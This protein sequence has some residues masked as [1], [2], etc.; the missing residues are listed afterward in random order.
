MSK[1]NPQGQQPENRPQLNMSAAPDL[2]YK[3]RDLFNVHVS[4]EDVLLEFGNLHRSQP[5]SAVLLDRIVLSPGNA[6]RLQQALAQAI[7]QMQQKIREMAA[8]K[9]PASG[10]N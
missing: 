8:Q 1:D 7:N 2:D 3:Y 10:A 9:P 5:G 6:I 4:A